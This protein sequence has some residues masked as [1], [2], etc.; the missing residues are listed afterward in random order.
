ML[1]DQELSGVAERKRVLVAESAELRARIRADTA[2]VTRRLH[3]VE[4]VGRLGA[5]VRP[6]LMF[7]AALVGARGVVRKSRV[8]GLVGAGLASAR[9]LWRLVR[10][11]R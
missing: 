8:L 4:V 1:W 7:G 11:R 2:A 6:A 10:G 3:W 9:M 5:F